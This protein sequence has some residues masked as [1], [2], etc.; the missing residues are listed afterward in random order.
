MRYLGVKWFVIY[1]EKFSKILVT[2]DG[3][4]KTFGPQMHADSRR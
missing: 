2:G 4:G 3:K 1:T